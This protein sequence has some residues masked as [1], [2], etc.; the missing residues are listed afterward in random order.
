M[1][2]STILDLALVV[3]LL[4]YAAN[5]WRQGFVSAVLGLVGL[6]GGALVA[7]RFAPG[8]L[9]EHAGV[10]LTT[11]F[12]VFVTIAVVL[13]VATTAQWLLLVLGSSIRSSMRLPGYRAADSALGALAVLVATLFVIWAVA[14]AVRA[15]GPPGL[16]AAVA[17]SRVVRAA[18]SVVPSRASVLVDDLTRALDADVFPRVF[19]GLGPEPIAA[20]PAPDGA[21]A[22]DPDIERALRSVIHVRAESGRCESTQVGSGW[23]SRRGRVVTNAHVVA[24]AERVQV[25]VGGRGAELAARVVAFDPERD[26]AVLSVPGLAAPALPT[27]P[28]LA[29]TDDA[30]LAGFP[31]DQ[32]LWVGAARVRDV[33]DARGADIYGSPGPTREIYSL[34]AEVR[35]GASGGPMLDPD[36]EVVGMIFATSLD[37]PQTGYALTLAEVQPVLTAARGT[38]SPVSTGRCARR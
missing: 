3:L 16:R 8:L 33:L 24:G 25:S 38:D 19:E 23:V 6:V 36:G 5:G 15:A 30:V 9:E 2:G 26:I 35:Q 21:L 37:D 29:R 20:V 13:F 7:M 22:G 34:R 10:D 4:S 28:E 18:D 32:G 1:S 11:P 27:G 31:G 17:D 12:G 14:G